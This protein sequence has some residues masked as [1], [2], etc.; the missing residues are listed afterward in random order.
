M[1]YQGINTGTTPND[2]TGD[3]LVDGGIKINSNFQ[4]VYN[5][6]GDGS[7]LAVGVVTVISAGT[8]VA[9]NTS[10]GSVQIS[11]PTPVS[12]ATT[13]VDI[14]RNLKAVGITTLGIV[15]GAT[16]YGDGSNLTGIAVTEN[17][18]TDSL[19]VSGVST[20]GA[21]SASNQYN[22]G[23]VTAIGGFVSTASTQAVQISFS[24]STLTFTVA[25]IGS[26][27]LTLS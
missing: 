23:I 26:T 20:L 5:L 22:T 18:S 25:G 10:T 19:V 9:V 14:S 16:Y 27:S 6:I 1:A 7:T 13:D 4:E 15:T 17:V 21:I 3:T 11:A 2:G 8:N 24:G 12:I